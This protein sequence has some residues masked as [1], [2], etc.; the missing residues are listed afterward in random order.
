MERFQLLGWGS[1]PL[2]IATIYLAVSVLWVVFSDQLVALL[3]QDSQL[4]TRV[5]TLK[6][7]FFV[8]STAALIYVLLRREIATYKK[9]SD[10]LAQSSQELRDIL[11][12]MPVGVV[13]SDGTTIEYI[14]INFSQ[15]YGYSLDEIPTDEQWFLLAYPD[16]SSREPLI[17]EWQQELMRARLQGTPIKPFEIHITCKN[18]EMRQA[19]ANAQMIGNRIVVIYTDITERE[20]LHNELVKFQKLES[21]GLLAG[22]LAHDFNNILTGIMGN[23]SYAQILMDAAHPATGPLKAAEHA[24]IRAVELTGQLLTFARGGEPV[25]KVLAIGELINESISLMLLGS[26]VKGET[27]VPEELWSVEAD[28]GQISQVLNNI[29]I[30]AVQAMPDGGRLKITAENC[31]IAEGSVSALSPGKYVCVCLEDNG[32]GMA[33]ETLGRVFDPYFTTKAEGSGLGLA[34]AYSIINRHGGTIT[35]DSTSGQGTRFTLMLPATEARP[36]V[37]E[38]EPLAAMPLKDDYRRRILV[39]DDE[40][41]ICDIASAMLDYLGYEV[42]TC[43]NGLEAIARY[44]KAIAA[45]EGYAAVIMDLTIPGSLGG[46]EAAQQILARD[47]NACLI[48]SSGYSHDPIMADFRSYGFQGVLAKPYKVGALG[49]ALAAVLPG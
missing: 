4:I 33:A 2:K 21:I 43:S 23:L 38:Q 26:K 39:M 49:Q 40:A 30:N 47:P 31:P 46:K 19:I 16:P 13:M 10:N 22:G 14:N 20:L 44:D 29:I 42:D 35:V 24:A 18:G 34:S 12:A 36:R 5:Q 28:G 11:D 45:G 15:R 37:Q 32:V 27:E 17:A 6:G 41:A 25:K 8:G 1:V 7:W 9:T 48:V 3:L